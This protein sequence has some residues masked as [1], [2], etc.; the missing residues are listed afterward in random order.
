MIKILRTNNKKFKLNLNNFLEKRRDSQSN[1]SSTVSK[2][3][4]D[5][6]KNKIKALKKYE[7]KFSKN[8]NIKIS[9]SDIKKEIN[10]LDLKVKN[11]ID[12]S[13]NRIKNFHIQ[14]LKNI[15][16]I[17][18]KDK[19]KNLLE[20]V[21]V[22]IESVGIYVPGNL[23][24]TLL[25][26]S[27]PAKI[28][29]VKRI[30]LATPKIN[31]KLNPAILYAAKK[32]GINEIYSMGGAQAI[33]SLTF[34][35]K[36][37]KI[38]GPG[39]KFVAEAKK[40]LS[41]KL[42]GTESMFAGPSEICVVADK[43]SDINQIATSIVSQAEHDLDSQCILITKHE[44][45]VKKVVK[46][47]F[48]LLKKLPRKKIAYH[49]IKKHGL[50]II[51]KQDK[52]IID[53][54]NIVSTEHLELLIKNSKKYIKKIFNVGSI[55]NGKYSPMC[56]SDFTVGTNHVLP[57]AGSSRFSSGLN[58]NE[59]IKK[60]SI[61]TLNKLGVEKIANPAITLAE[62]EQLFGHAESIRS[63]IRRN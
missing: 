45:I 25:M 34:I 20:Y 19:Y 49:S 13:Y 30:V 22:P 29:K 39:N 35:Q 46:K 36:V 47:I 43:Y 53:A 6:K 14:Q 32:V 62:Y 58:I 52:E 8:K 5:I 40:Q 57:T 17:K 59:F 50:I 27:I 51:S 2:I 63:R 10:S 48:E 56:L 11:A 16:N 21:N 18:Y 55:C 28:A 15:T 60:I 42:I 37:N 23:P 41:G 26:N 24:S 44:V 38:I 61:V 7:L 33:G 31:G 4:L 3:L 1:V 9:N 54:I 12:F